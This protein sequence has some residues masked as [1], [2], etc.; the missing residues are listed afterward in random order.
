MDLSLA[1]A[2]AVEPLEGAEAYPLSAPAPQGAANGGGT[3]MGFWPLVPGWDEG[4]FDSVARSQKSEASTDVAR[5][6]PTI[7]LLS[8]D[9][10]LRVS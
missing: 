9:Y 10:R 8:T 4:F 3:A 1:P 2:T 6:L 7:W 5:W